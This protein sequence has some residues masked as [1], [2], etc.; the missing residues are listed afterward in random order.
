[1]ECNGF[2]STAFCCDFSDRVTHVKT[3]IR[4]KYRR[5][6]EMPDWSEDEIAGV[7]YNIK[8]G[9]ESWMKIKK[10]ARER[11]AWNAEQYLRLIDDGQHFAEAAVEMHAIIGNEKQNW[12]DTENGVVNK[13]Q[14]ETVVEVSASLTKDDSHTVND[15][16]GAQKCR[17]CGNLIHGHRSRKFC[18]HKCSDKWNHDV[19]ELLKPS[20]KIME[21]RKCPKCG[22]IFKPVN[23]SQ[24]YCSRDCSPHHHPQHV[25]RIYLYAA[26]RV[27]K[28]C[29]QCKD[30]FEPNTKRQEF[31]SHSCSSRWHNAVR[32]MLK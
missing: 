22:S 20:S 17:E 9:V 29:P 2:A 7:R 14:H 25:D 4:Q 15:N 3:K 10:I 1:M 12:R 32:K 26:W 8:T 19:D 6:F 27:Q 23:G 5:Q 16:T 21:K 13:P 30:G 18:S 24:K 31:C 11:L 28:F